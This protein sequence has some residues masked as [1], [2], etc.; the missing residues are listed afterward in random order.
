MACRTRGVAV[1]ETQDGRGSS[2]LLLLMY[3]IYGY[4]AMYHYWED[5]GGRYR[6]GK[7]GSG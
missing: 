5:G 4:L 6:I 2:D 7:A 1:R 3:G